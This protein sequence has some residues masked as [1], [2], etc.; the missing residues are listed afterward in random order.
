MSDMLRLI[1]QIALF[2]LIV[3]LVAIGGYTDALIAT[4][5]WFLASVIRERRND[6]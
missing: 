3:A 4:C 6:D 1:Y 5:T 2:V